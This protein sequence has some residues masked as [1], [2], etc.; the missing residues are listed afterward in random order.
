MNLR[1]V[2]S[3]GSIAL[4]F[5]AGGAAARLLALHAPAR[6]AADFAQPLVVVTAWHAYGVAAFAL[7]AGAIACA[8]LA[9]TGLALRTRPPRNAGR[10]V[11]L[12]ASAAILAA[13][14]WPFIFSSDVYAYAAYG[15]MAAGGIDPYRLAPPQ[16]HGP[17]IEAARWQWGGAFPVCVYGPAFVAL[18]RI[19][20]ERL[21]GFGVAATLWG[22]RAL[23]AAAFIGSIAA[24]DVALAGRTARERFVVLC[25]YG[26]NPVVLW[27]VA[28][29]HNDA[30]VLL[31]VFGGA[32]V[33]AR[34]APFAGGVIAGSAAVIKATALP[35]ALG[36]ALDALLF[37]AASR[38]RTVALGTA[39]SLVV[40]GAF[41][42]PPLL[43]ALAAV[44]TS[45][46]YAPAASLQGLIGL[47]PVVTLA[48]V[49]CGYGGARLRARKRD[50][51]AWL[52][53][54]V[55]LSL[56]NGYPWYALWVLPAALVAGSGLATTA[57]WA[58]TIFSV[59]RYLPDAAGNVVGANALAALAQ[60]V[61]LLLAP[62]AIGRPAPIRKKA[63]SP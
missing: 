53:I 38:G 43:P 51:F 28:E 48:L 6:L 14:T 33:I 5:V 63:T 3:F 18:A 19:V 36:L 50:G 35:L 52:G 16:L 25:A 54:A 24:L 49:A 59:V 61:P 45:G 55:W 26:L 32:A 7:L 31:A 10:V 17:F 58:A 60:A 62:F 29:G 20:L 41:A 27:S 42:V 12:A 40:A 8:T 56:P 47:A 57:L 39:A 21:H 46:H 44:G 15:A 9:T 1:R 4:C 11:M 30:F 13:W 22:L 37:G 34:G 2:A 23:A